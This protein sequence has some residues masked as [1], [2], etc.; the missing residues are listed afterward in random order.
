MFELG[1]TI[2]R[3]NTVQLILIV[4]CLGFAIMAKNLSIN[5]SHLSISDFISQ[6][7]ANIFTKNPQYNLFLN[8][9]LPSILYVVSCLLLLWM[10][11][12]NF[13]S[14]ILEETKLNWSLRFLLGLSQIVLFILF[15]YTGGKLA[16]YSATFSIIVALA[17][18][19]IISGFRDER[20]GT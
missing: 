2:I 14:L 16:L 12:T 10:G 3:V 5:L 8:M 9:V 6:S 7:F 17:V 19:V 13:F 20:S 1:R 11:V 18:G 4:L 15:L